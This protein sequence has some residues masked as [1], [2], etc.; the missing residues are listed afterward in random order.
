VGKIEIAFNFCSLEKSAAAT[1]AGT[2]WQK[3]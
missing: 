1:H 2:N 3:T